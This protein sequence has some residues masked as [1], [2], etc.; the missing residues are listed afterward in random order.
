M[1][2]VHG[3]ILC[4]GKSTRMGQD[5]TSVML[6]GK[7]LLTYSIELFASLN[8]DFHLS[9]NPNQKEL[10]ENYP[11][12]ID[13]FEAVGPL[14]GIL[15]GLKSIGK[16]LLI[17]PV[18]MPQLTKNL[19]LK[20]VDAFGN[21]ELVRCF[22]RNGRIEPFPS[23]WKSEATSLLNELLDE[24]ELSLQKCITRLP[25]HLSDS[26]DSEVFRNLNYPE[27]LG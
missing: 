27:D 21:H 26:T 7:P 3:L 1:K 22:Q 24:R 11:S 10:I 19:L 20:L 18:D 9:V 5:K 16:D 2:S 13:Q 25:H 15:T 4:G 6:Q 12:V 8:I 17:I 14:G 23:L